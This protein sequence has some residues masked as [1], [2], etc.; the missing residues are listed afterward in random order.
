MMTDAQ[1]I[2]A[3][4]KG[5]NTTFAQLYDKYRSE[6]IGY[7]R[8]SYRGDEQ[9]IFDIYQDSCMALYHNILSKR[10]TAQNLSSA[11]LKTYLF[12]IGRNKLV[13]LYRRNK[14]RSKVLLTENINQNETEMCTGE[15]S[16]REIII[17]KVVNQ[18]SEPC[19]TILRLYYWD[20]KSMKE[21][22]EVGGYS[23]ADSAKAQKSKCMAKLKL[24]I[25][26][27]LTTNERRTDR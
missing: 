9:E 21:I 15:L 8:K 10:L 27:I 13:D 6:F 17:Q 2:Q 4:A 5:D 25:T 1:I 18:M 23:N 7:I 20:D 3:I 12:T 11:S 24:Y 14:T 22:A 16:E 26:N 19:N